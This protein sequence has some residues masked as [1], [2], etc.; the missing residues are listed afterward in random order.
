M[1]SSLI[2]NTNQVHFAS[3]LAM[4]NA[5][6]VAMFEAL[7]ASGLNGF[8]GC[9]SEIFETALNEFYQNTSV[10]DGKVVSTVQ[11]K[12][13]EISEE[14]FARNFQLLVEGLIDINEVPKDL[15]F[16]SRT[17]FSFTDEQLTTS[18]KKRELK[19]EYRLLSDIVAKSITVKEGSFDAVTHERDIVAVSTVIDIAVDASDFVGVFRRG[20]DVHMILSES[21][22]SSSGSAHPD[23]PPTSADSSLHFN[24]Y[25]ICLSQRGTDVHMIL[26]ES[27]SSSSG[28]AHPDPAVLANFSQRPLDTDLTSP[29][30]S[31]MDSRVLFTTDDTPIGVEQILMPTTVT[32]QDFR[33][34]LIQ[35]RAL[36]SQISTE[37][38]ASSGFLRWILKVHGLK[39]CPIQ[40]WGTTCLCCIAITA[41]I[42]QSGSIT[43]WL[44]SSM[45]FVKGNIRLGP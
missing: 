45:Q 38:G 21:S 35:L 9:M 26:S 18:C 4:D 7:V 25:D 23:S 20:T 6:M 16:Y 27:S 43:G 13:V 31:T 2:G 32:P 37:H 22:S 1:A 5:E 19:I 40:L 36:V 44:H 14:I 39:L 34:P 12:L 33:E 28:S 3:V 10:R 15:I 11:G 24:A 42:A 41:T 29:N 30:P 8:L 17:E